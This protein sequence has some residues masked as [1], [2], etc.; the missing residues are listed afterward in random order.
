MIVQSL[1]ACLAEY[2]LFREATVLGL[3]AEIGRFDDSIVVK[4]EPAEARNL[5]PVKNA[6][7]MPRTLFH[8]P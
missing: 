8:K 5:D 2:D 3:K 4:V 7:T 1:N 6:F